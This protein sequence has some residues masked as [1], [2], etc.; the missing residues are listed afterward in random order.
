M[1]PAMQTQL[2]ACENSVWMLVLIKTSLRELNNHFYPEL[3][4]K[5]VFNPYTQR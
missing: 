5:K 1:H 2:E 3:H 4:F